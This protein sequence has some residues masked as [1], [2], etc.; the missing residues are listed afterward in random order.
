MYAKKGNLSPKC[1][2]HHTESH[3][4]H[5][6]RVRYGTSCMQGDFSDFEFWG[7]GEADK[8][9]VHVIAPFIGRKNSTL[10]A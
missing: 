2:K 1:R 3:V 10:T 5:S 4:E 9:R 8:G 6:Q 7:H